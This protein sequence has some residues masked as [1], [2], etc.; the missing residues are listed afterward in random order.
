MNDLMLASLLG[1]LVCAMFLD[2]GVAVVSD[3][4]ASTSTKG[5]GQ[6]RFCHLEGRSDDHSS[7][8]WG[9]R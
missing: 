2:L 6:P 8:E 9:A 5:A 4:P 7:T 3:R 1:N